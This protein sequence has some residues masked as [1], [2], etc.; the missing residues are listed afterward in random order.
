M[1][2]YA[3][4]AMHGIT[5]GMKEAQRDA[6]LAVDSGYWPL[7]RF[8]PGGVS[9]SDTVVHGGTGLSWDGLD[10]SLTLSYPRISMARAVQYQA[11]TQP[12]GCTTQDGGPRM[13]LA[14]RATQADMTTDC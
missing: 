10:T 11:C 3:P 8:Q 5:E 13:L 14:C 12:E 9:R 6:R 2:A 1:V 7:Y 4:C